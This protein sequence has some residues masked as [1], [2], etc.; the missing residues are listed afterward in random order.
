MM[1]FPVSKVEETGGNWWKLNFVVWLRFEK[2][3]AECF[4]NYYACECREKKVCCMSLL[5]FI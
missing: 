1:R 4:R 3:F 5:Q 2:I